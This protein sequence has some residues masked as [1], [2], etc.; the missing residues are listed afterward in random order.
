MPKAANMISQ[1]D[2]GGITHLGN[3]LA[4]ELHNDRKLVMI[5]DIDA[6]VLE[7]VVNSLGVMARTLDPVTLLIATTGGEANPTMGI[8]SVIRDLQRLGIKVTGQVHGYCMS[9]GAIILQA[10][11]QRVISQQGLLMVHGPSAEGIG[12]DVKNHEAEVTMIRK[13]IQFWA[14]LFAE[15]NTS[16][17]LHRHEIAYWTEIQQESIPRYFTPAEALD[18]GLVD[19][20]VGG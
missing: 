15:R 19:E 17:D 18:A 4:A 8:I 2:V 10:C 11:D 13:L 12:G 16:K 9:A 7:G 5:G 6:S 1:V 3:K 20:V 14:E